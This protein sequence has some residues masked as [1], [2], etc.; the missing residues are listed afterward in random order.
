MKASWSRYDNRAGES[1]VTDFQIRESSIAIRFTN[2]GTYLYD[3]RKPGR[4]DLE[5]MKRLALAGRGLSTFI[6]THVKDRYA[7]RIA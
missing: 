4:K 5:Q 3:A 2:G 1:G 7:S 6:S